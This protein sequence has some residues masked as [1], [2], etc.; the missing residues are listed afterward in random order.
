MF[1]NCTIGQYLNVKIHAYPLLE[2]VPSIVKTKIVETIK[3]K[4]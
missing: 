3:E 2:S 1:E 4:K